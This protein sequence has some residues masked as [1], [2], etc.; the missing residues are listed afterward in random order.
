MNK[1]PN[2]IVRSQFFDS[3]HKSRNYYASSSDGF[4]DY[5]SKKEMGFGENEGHSDKSFNYYSYMTRENAVAG[6]WSNN[7]NKID[8]PKESHV[9]SLVVSFEKDYAFEKNLFNAEGTKE[10]IDKTIGSFLQENKLD[11]ANVKYFASHH[12]NTDNPHV[13]ILMYEEKPSR[14][15]R[16]TGELEYKL[17]RQFTVK[18]FKN[19]KADMEERMLDN[20]KVVPWEEASKARAQVR[21][22]VKSSLDKLSLQNAYILSRV[23]ELVNSNDTGR[24]AYNSLP[25]ETQGQIR[26]EFE[27][28]RLINDKV[29]KAFSAMERWYETHVS[30]RTK[31][32]DTLFVKREQEAKA[33][34]YNQF[35]K[36]ALEANTPIDFGSRAPVGQRTRAMINRARIVDK[37]VLAKKSRYNKFASMMADK[38][39]KEASAAMKS[40]EAEILSL[41]KEV[42]KDLER[43]AYE[44]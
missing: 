24:V 43:G 6:Y 32:T 3:H 1:S 22:E 29:D 13:H 38:A 2:I 14:Q 10:L 26:K 25:R 37:Q 27:E 15:N 16:E 34:I 5:I 35:I 17:S 12:S 20:N 36:V 33:S 41:G 8:V 39:L 44:R 31:D 18:S 19:W 40:L 23:R 9:W 11:P 7:D 21:A 28:Y 4:L 42:E 30:D